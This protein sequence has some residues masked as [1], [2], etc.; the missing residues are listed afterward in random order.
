[1]SLNEILWSHGLNMQE[2]ACRMNTRGRQAPWCQCHCF[3]V[4]TVHVQC[5]IVVSHMPRSFI[6]WKESHSFCRSRP[7]FLFDNAEQMY[8]C[9]RLFIFFLQKL[10][11]EHEAIFYRLCSDPLMSVESRVFSAS[12]STEFILFSPSGSDEIESKCHWE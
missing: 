12:H 6:V 2:R 7:L 8:Y 5:I 10:N 9:S 11:R 3:T 4:L 1:M